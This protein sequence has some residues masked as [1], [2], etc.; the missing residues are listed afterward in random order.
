MSRSESVLVTVD[1][2]NSKIVQLK[3]GLD[4][5]SFPFPVIR[6]HKKSIEDV[7]EIDK[8]GDDNFVPR[9]PRLLRLT[10]AHPFN[11]ESPLTL[12]Y[13]T[14]FLTP[15]SLHFVRN[16]G[17]VPRCEM[18]DMLDWEISIEGMVE[19][20][21]TINL[22]SIMEDFQQ[23]TV[24]VTICCAGNRR[25]EQNMVKKGTGFN[26]GAAGVSNSLWTGPFLKDVIARANPSKKA[27]YVW[28]EG[29]DDPANGAYGTCILM[30]WVNDPEH[31]IMLAYKQNG[32]F[33]EPDHGRPLRVVIPGVIGGRSVKW[34]KRLVISDKPSDNWYHY[35]DNKVLP[36]FLTPEEAK[37][38]DKWWKD[39]RYT[40]YNLNV[41]SV[42]VYPENQEIMKFSENSI[43]ETYP[44]RG[45]AYNGGGIRVGR[46][47]VSLDK[48]KTWRLTEIDYPEDR[49]REAGEFE[50]FGGLVNVCDRMSYLCWC[51]WTVDIPKSE[52]FNS[53]E[54]LVRAMDDN[55]VTQPRD[56]YWNVTSMLNNWWYRVAIVKDDLSGDIRFEH[57]VIANKSGGWMDRVKD[58][59]GDI[60]S[61]N[62]GEKDL[63]RAEQ[64]TTVV[65]QKDLDF[66]M[67]TNP[68]K[69]HVKISKEELSRHATDESP[70][71]VVRG[72]VYDGLPYLNEHPGG[73]Q[74]I[75]LVLGDDATEDFMAVHSDTAKRML[76]NY[77]VGYLDDSDIIVKE[78]NEQAPKVSTTFLNAKK[79]KKSKLIGKKVISK[80]T[81]IFTFELDHPDQVT[82]LPVGQH[83]YLRLKDKDG[84][85]MRAYTPKSS[86]LQKGTL[87]I[88]IK[89]YFPQNGVPGGRLT[90]A[91]ENVAIGEFLEIKG[92]IGE[93]EYKG[94]GE[95]IKHGKEQKIDSFLMVGGGSGLTPP[96]QIFQE[97][98]RLKETH[99]K[100]DFIFGNRTE[101]DIL[102]RDELDELFTT[103]DNFQL[104]H[105]LS[106]PDQGWTGLKG[107]IDSKILDNYVSRRGGKVD[108]FMLLVCGPKAMEE[109]II[110]WA[111]V[112][113]VPPEN[114]HKF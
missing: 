26:W 63:D 97:I 17:P 43:E 33:L 32:E 111:Q 71:F 1:T 36:T 55:M 41:Q 62:W 113:G 40:L 24:P 53:Q 8:R 112:S 27:R 99:I 90:M 78:S 29:C 10:G 2:E 73:A 5:S 3:G 56:M 47:E 95:C 52:L 98:A 46:V 68:E 12:L 58:Q 16:H 7:L 70:W 93:F 109:N 105:V 28:M 37:K 84:Y 25:K 72:Q 57:P 87:D 85:V 44:V 88:L 69:L 45:F 107:Y 102:L 79:W 48:G 20:P 4:L 81:R 23:Y 96:Y 35:Y 67:M 21:M 91:M 104:Q 19:N 77:H 106:Q 92:P 59:G 82:G 9:D 89:V 11:C 114:I 83:L 18:D 13:D 75:T 66:L 42:T 110:E 76:A 64:L 100:V 65:T 22:K 103:F 51:F 49:Y 30:P 6:D 31:C 14:G 60:L 54:I 50:L 15:S 38:D 80:D 34:L 94:N 74:S 108:D 39:E 61:R 101:R 86:H